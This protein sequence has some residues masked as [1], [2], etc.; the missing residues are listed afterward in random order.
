MTPPYR[1]QQRSSWRDRGWHLRA[2][3]CNWGRDFGR[4]SCR[5]RQCREGR[6]G[7]DSALWSTGPS[8]RPRYT[9]STACRNR[10][11]PSAKPV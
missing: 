11:D 1:T 2:T 5:Y 6:P 4:L 3:F 8:T 9:P 7:P 10:P